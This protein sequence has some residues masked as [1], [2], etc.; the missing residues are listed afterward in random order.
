MDHG[1]CHGG[2]QYEGDDAHG[3]HHRQQVHQL[4]CARVA[5]FQVDAGNAAVVDLTE[6]LAEVGAPLMPH[7]G[8]GEK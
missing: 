5:L 7:P 4:K 2:N 8:I 3:E 1:A 6:E